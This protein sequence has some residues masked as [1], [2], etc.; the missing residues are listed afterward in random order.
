M[1]L[2]PLMLLLA[3]DEVDVGLTGDWDLSLNCTTGELPICADGTV[4]LLRMEDEDHGEHRSFLP[5]HPRPDGAWTGM[6]GPV[7]AEH[8]V[9]VFLLLRG[10]LDDPFV[11]AEA[12]SA[13]QDHTLQI[14]GAPESVCWT[15]RWAWVAEDG[16]EDAAGEVELVRRERACR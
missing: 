14:T 7:V 3:C 6:P 16:T 12:R 8:G 15:A 9:E 11:S 2:W 1:R 4:G 10:D 5:G 13:W